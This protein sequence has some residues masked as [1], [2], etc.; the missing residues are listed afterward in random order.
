VGYLVDK[1]AESKKTLID[2][3]NKLSEKIDGYDNHVSSISSDVSKVQSQ[4][5]LAMWSIPILQK[6]QVLPVKSIAGGGGSSTSA[7]SVG[8]MGTAPS[9]SPSDSSPAVQPQQPQSGDHTASLHLQFGH[10]THGERDSD[11]RRPWV[12]KMDFLV[13]DGSDV[14]VWLDKCASYFHLYGIPPNFRVRVASLHMVGRESH[15]FQS[16]PTLGLG[17]RGGRLGP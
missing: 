7:N 16:G 15:W 14:R 13:F 4:V 11:Q 10:P 3:M 2:A 1:M 17:G 12:P 6:E 5:D 8:V 9:S